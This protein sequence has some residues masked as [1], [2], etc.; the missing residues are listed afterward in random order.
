MVVPCVLLTSRQLVGANAG[1][2]TLVTKC[3][4][5]LKAV[6]TVERKPQNTAA[7]PLLVMFM[8]IISMITLVSTRAI[9]SVLTTNAYSMVTVWWSQTVQQ[10]MVMLILEPLQP[11]HRSKKPLRQQRHR[12]VVRPHLLQMVVPCVLLTSRQL[13][14]ANAGRM[15]LVTKCKLFLKAVITVE[16]K[17]QNT[18]A[19][20]LVVMVTMLFMLIISLI[21]LVSTRAIVSM[22][23]TNAYSMVTAWWSQ[24]VQEW[25]VMLLLEP[26]PPPL[27]SK[28]PLRQ[29]RHR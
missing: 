18:A 26:L 24:T 28:K 15:T 3:K 22:L 12:R 2:M 14:G 13:V 29:P 6:I 10:W 1:R 16:R 27:R 9:V 17:P 11:P 7:S 5:F 20:P 8:L 4:L 23:T 19:S 25:M 21:T